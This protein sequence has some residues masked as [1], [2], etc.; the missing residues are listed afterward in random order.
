MSCELVVKPILHRHDGA[1][2]E[3]KST[4]RNMLCPSRY[5][6]QGSL[7]KPAGFLIQARK[8]RHSIAFQSTVDIA[9]G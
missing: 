3:L 8:S 5:P 6:S 7:W 9:R 1:E 4:H 2:W